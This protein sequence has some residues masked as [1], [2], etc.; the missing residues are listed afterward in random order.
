MFK[1]NKKVT[2]VYHHH[3]HQVTHHRK[4]LNKDTNPYNVLDTEQHESHL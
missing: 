3:H 2:F 4:G 1:T